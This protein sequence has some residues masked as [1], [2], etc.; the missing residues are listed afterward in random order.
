MP[1][2]YRFLPPLEFLYWCLY[3]RIKPHSLFLEYTLLADLSFGIYFLNRFTTFCSFFGKYKGYMFKTLLKMNFTTAS[4]SVGNT[5]DILKRSVRQIYEWLYLEFLVRFIALLSY[6]S[7]HL[8]PLKATSMNSWRK[9][10]FKK[11]NCQ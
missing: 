1:W 2:F 6:V 9:S 7:Y 8:N 3:F 4:I 11:V 5:S 10:T